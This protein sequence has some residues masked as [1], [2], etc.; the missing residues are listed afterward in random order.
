AI[1]PS[2]RT[3][4]NCPRANFGLSDLRQ[5]LSDLE[6]VALALEILMYG[7]PDGFFFIHVHIGGQ[8]PQR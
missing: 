2:T 6:H 7:G 5:H 4:A 8:V 1:S 3:W